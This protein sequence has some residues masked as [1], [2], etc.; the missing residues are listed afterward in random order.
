MVTSTRHTYTLD[1]VLRPGSV[2]AA[3]SSRRSATSA[4]ASPR[5]VRTRRGGMIRE[6]TGS[7]ILDG[8][9]TGRPYDVDAL[10]TALSRL[11]LF[12]ATH[13]NELE[14][15]EINPFV[16]LPQGEGAVGLDAVLVARQD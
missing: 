10:A 16:V 7:V 11:S 14:S 2:L 1:A 12:A 13:G 9:R 5:S 6:T 3:S 15:A 4:S 8:A